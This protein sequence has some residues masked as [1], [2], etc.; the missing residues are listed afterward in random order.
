MLALLEPCI[1]I[2]C[3]CI[4]VLRPIF[5]PIFVKVSSRLP[6]IKRST[7]TGQSAWTVPIV[8]LFSMVSG[9]RSRG[10]L[11]DPLTRGFVDEQTDYQTIET[12][13]FG[14][15][16]SLNIQT[17]FSPVHKYDK[18]DVFIPASPTLTNN[19]KEFTRPLL[20]QEKS[21]MSPQNR[22]LAGS[23]H[24]IRPSEIVQ[25]HRKAADQQYLSEKPLPALPRN[26]RKSF[27]MDM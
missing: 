15:P 21:P 4:P 25:L 11:Q 18:E 23:P 22:V 13:A 27:R 6:S 2:V 20:A 16:R 5:R 19:S 17:K 26:R 10:S 3:A 24:R 1:G 7:P 12:T 14:H 8:M 9:K